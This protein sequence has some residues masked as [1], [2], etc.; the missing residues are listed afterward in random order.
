[1]GD[2]VSLLHTFATNLKRYR[3]QIGLSQEEFADKAGLH[4]TY[5]SL[6]EREKRSIANDNIAKIASALEID[7]YLLFV[8]DANEIGSSEE[9][10]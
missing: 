9:V 1:L 3:I 2:F 6:V 5:I 10:K 8:E 4:R 7:A